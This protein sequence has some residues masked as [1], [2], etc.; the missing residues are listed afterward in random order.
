[1]ASRIGW[2]TWWLLAFMAAPAWAQEGAADDSSP[3]A[4]SSMEAAPS[5]DTTANDAGG[6]Q[7]E[8]A[9]EETSGLLGDEQVL[10]EEEL[11][12]EIVRS[13]T[14]P[15]EDPTRNYYFLGFFY[16]HHFTPQFILNL[17]T[18]E[19]T[20]ANNP[21][22]GLQFTYRKDGFDIITSLWYQSYFVEG[23]FRGSGDTEFETEIIDSNLKAMFA[24]VT[25]LWSTEFNDIFSIQYGIGLGIG[26]VF[27]N[28]Y[29]DEA[30]PADRTP[31]SESFGGFSRCNGPRDP[32]GSVTGND[33]WC[34][35][36]AVGDGMNG[37]HF[38][39]KARKWTNGGSVPNV[40]FRAALPHLALRIKPI[41]QLMFR[42]EGGFDLFSG[43]F[44]G[45]SLNVGFGGNE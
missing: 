2:S 42:I 12:T 14:D 38:G 21:A 27:G 8:A 3:A 44:V 40:W 18:D 22:L 30:Y 15:Y 13:S 41:K 9:P 37:G 34:D 36:V 11:G 17:F 4:A 31:G 29:R 6:T 26:A 20:P 35:P 24:G 25:F 45:G 39:V 5:A 19:S 16:D 1:M 43:F 10:A 23:P 28:M 32:D 33:G 7:A